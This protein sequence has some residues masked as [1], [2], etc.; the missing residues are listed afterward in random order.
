MQSRLFLCLFNTGLFFL[1]WGWCPAQAAEFTADLIVTSRESKIVY[2]LKVKDNRYRIEKVNGPGAIPSMPTIHDRSSRVSWGLNPVTKQYI[3]ET[4]PARTL[5][6]DPIAGWEAMRSSLK[7]LPAG[8]G[9]V[10]GYTC[11]I[12]E[13]QHP[14]TAR[15]ANRVWVSYEL[16]FTLKEISYAVNGD[17]T[18]VV[19]NIKQRPVDPALFKLPKGY[20]RATFPG[21][22]APQKTRP[23]PAVTNALKGQAPWGRRIGAGGRIQVKFDPKRPV[24]IGF[25]N[26]GNSAASCTY[27]TYQKGDDHTPVKT[28]HIAMTRKGQRKKLSLGKNKRTEWVVIQ[29]EKGLIYA[30]MVNEKDPF[31]SDSYALQE[32]YLTVKGGQGI[33]VAPERK[34]II[35]VSGDSQDSPD[36]EVFLI[37]Y[38][39]QYT[40]KV[41]EEK[42]KIPNLQTKTWEFSP[43]QNIQTC[44]I[45]VG[46]TGGIKYRVVQPAPAR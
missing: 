39:Q 13:Y 43:D 21:K 12:F 25:L 24:K 8:T 15:V 44:E 30:S 32:G 2:D 5:M 37:C 35:T 11:H 19:Q 7:A 27:T 18:L 36:S 14:G 33:S 41:F 9:T 31:T 17:T 45:L 42:I 10:N 38:Q 22:V 34:L 40:N 6:M 16:N 4:D 20:A 29:G 46:K 23:L 28:G 26:Q 1:F 3:E